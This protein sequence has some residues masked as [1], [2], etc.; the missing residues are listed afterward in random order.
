MYM[1][2]ACFAR[3][4]QRCTS[5]M[6]MH[7]LLTF[8]EVMLISKTRNQLNQNHDKEERGSNYTTRHQTANPRHTHLRVPMTAHVPCPCHGYSQAPK[9][10]HSRKYPWCRIKTTVS[11][12]LRPETPHQA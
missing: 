1:A 7:F 10:T 12:D 4:P 8:Q 6:Y 5:R 2:A 9:N 3:A 11:N